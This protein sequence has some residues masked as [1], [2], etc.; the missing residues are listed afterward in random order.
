M[1]RVREDQTESIAVVHNPAFKR[2]RLH[3]RLGPKVVPCSSGE[4]QEHYKRKQVSGSQLKEF[5]KEPLMRNESRKPLDSKA[6]GKSIP[7]MTEGIRS[8][9]CSTPD[10]GEGCSFCDG[11]SYK[12]RLRTSIRERT[13]NIDGIKT[14]ENMRLCSMS[15]PILA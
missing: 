1:S 10:P 8:E 6:S 12:R 9:Y 15:E 4:G 11:G 5:G 14:G 2:R 3:E 7:R 13:T